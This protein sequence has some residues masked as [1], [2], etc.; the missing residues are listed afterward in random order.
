MLGQIAFTLNGLSAPKAGPADLLD[1]LDP[2]FFYFGYSN[3]DGSWLIIRQDRET[4]E[5]VFATT[6]FPDLAT[7]FENREGLSYS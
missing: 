1:E 7:A 4:A 2:D 5:D 6:G 3:S